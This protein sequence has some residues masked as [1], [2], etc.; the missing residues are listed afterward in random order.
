MTRSLRSSLAAFAALGVL[1]VGCEVD[2][3][4]DDSLDGG[5]DAPAD[6]T[7]TDEPADEG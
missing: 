6:D 3:P 2:S 1:A 4:A 7:S 5:V